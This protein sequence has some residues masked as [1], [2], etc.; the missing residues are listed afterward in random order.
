MKRYFEISTHALVITAFLALAMTGRLDAPSIVSFSVAV[1]WSLYR[2]MRGR[3]ALLTTGVTFY[4]SCA[5][6]VFFVFDSLILSRSFIA[7]TIHMVLFLELAKLHQKK[8]D[9]DYFYLIVLAFLMVL[10]AASLTVDIS[11]IATLLLFLIALVATLMSFD[12][13]RSQRSSATETHSS[14]VSLTGI[15]VWATAWI[16][17]LGT[18]LFFLIPRIG[19]GYFSRAAVPPVLLSGFSD[20][21]RLGEIGR[22]KLSSAV[23]MRAKRVNGRPSS[24]LK[25]RGVALDRFD[26]R[27][28]HKTDTSRDEI[29]PAEGGLYSIQ[30]LEHSGDGVR[31]DILLEPMSTTTLFGPYHVRSVTSR[32]DSI[33]TDHDDSI[34][35]RVQ[36]QRRIQ[37]Q[38]LSEIPN[39]NRAAAAT[40]PLDMARYLQL[41]ENLDARVTVLARDITKGATTPMEKVSS[42]ETYLRRNYKY[43]LDLTWPPGQQPL[44]TFLFDAK[45]GHCEYFASALA[46]LARAA[47][48]PTRLVNG[49]QMG[50]FNPVGSDYIVRESDAHSWVE[51]YIPGRGWTE[52]DA[53]P[54]DMRPMDNGWAVQLGHYVDAMELM[55]SSYVLVYDNESQ[56][57]LFRKAQERVQDFQADFRSGADDWSLGLRRFGD[58]MSKAMRVVVEAAWFWVLV[59]AAFIGTAAFRNRRFLRTQWR[60]WQLRRG[61]GVAD[62]DVVARLFHRAAKLAEQRNPTRLPAQTW[63]EWALGLQ[64]SS[65]RTILM[66]ALTVFERSTYGHE[67]ASDADFTILENAIKQLKEM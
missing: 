67:H 45:T 23:V 55:W 51:A 38:V 11:F 33:S 21:V 14:P 39:R 34:F 57:Q 30:P 24:G 1:M 53:T 49:F 19:T 56:W 2:T 31:Y 16:V 47:G 15:S 66:S 26:G 60:I 4:L 22:I 65:R 27:S 54:L 32:Q 18:G 63:R 13:V 3:P 42:I 40:P 10:A 61:T 50:E 59:L 25:W 9:R 44:R 6:I 12:I 37:Y 62:A 36:Q 41:P 52:F 58:R 28:W 48:I 5:Y 8:S 43:T 20:N 7:A 35:I 46:I 64:D 29:R 17:V